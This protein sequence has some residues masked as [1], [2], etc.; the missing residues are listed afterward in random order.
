MNKNSQLVAF[1][2]NLS[3]ITALKE[4]YLKP[5]SHWLGENITM[6]MNNVVDRVFRK[7]ALSEFVKNRKAI[8]GEW[9]GG[10]LVGPNMNKIEYIY[11]SRHRE[12]LE[13][14][15]GGWKI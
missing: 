8:F 15:Y 13:I 5:Q 4:G 9:K 12:A 14:C 1:A 6:D 2:E 7:E 10:E 11:G 3:S